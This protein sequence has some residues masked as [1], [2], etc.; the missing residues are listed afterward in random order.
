MKEDAFID[1][2]V[3]K[4]SELKI[5]DMLHYMQFLRL[6]DSESDIIPKVARLRDMEPVK[7]VLEL[8]KMK[9][10]ERSDVHNIPQY[11]YILKDFKHNIYGVAC[12]RYM[13]N[14][15]HED[16]EG[17]IG[18]SI[19]PMFR[20]QGAG[21]FFLKEL[22]MIADRDFKLKD[23]LLCAD[24]NNIASQ[25][26]IKKVG[27][28]YQD[29]IY[30]HDGYI[31]RYTINLMK[32]KPEKKTVYLFN[33]QKDLDAKRIID[34]V[35]KTMHIL[36]FSYQEICEEIFDHLEPKDSSQAKLAYDMGMDLLK[37]HLNHY[38]NYADEAIL[39]T[40]FDKEA[41]FEI[42]NLLDDKQ[43]N[44]VSIYIKEDEK[45]LFDAYLSKYLDSHE[46]HKVIGLLDEDDYFKFRFIKDI[47][48]LPHNYVA[49]IDQED[50]VES[51]I[52]KIKTN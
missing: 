36:S 26:L 30:K 20:E 34:K 50:L 52:S 2:H 17:H 11:L 41:Y 29:R 33:Y 32:R 12:I 22:L 37:Y 38:L 40:S 31:H 9:Y 51:I 3:L 49:S 42:K 45:K 24:D 15:Y 5:E 48:K 35:S 23:I 4:V 1:L 6:F 14:N 46:I 43:I 18:L 39:A 13:L 8:E 28:I 44:L 16:Y 25:Q 7:F 27:G 21:E 10:A 19:A 47:H